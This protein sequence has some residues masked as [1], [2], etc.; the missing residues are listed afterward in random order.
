MSTA[1]FSRRRLIIAL[2]ASA[3]P[4]LAR[5]QPAKLEI[6]V[7]KAPSCGC[8]KDWITYLEAAGFRVKAN[9]TGNNAARA[10]LGMPTKFGSCHTAQ[11]AGYV[12]EG[13]VPTRE[14]ERLLRER[15]KAVGLSVPNMPLGSP[16]MDGP[17]YNNQRDPY[18]VLLI[19]ADGSSKVFASYNRPGAK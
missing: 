4:M 7:W 14:I 10:R 5:S 3:W 6:E 15:P 12:I 18:D 13:H 1:F 17:Q 16:G 8:C 19:Q 2:L 11:I 9:D